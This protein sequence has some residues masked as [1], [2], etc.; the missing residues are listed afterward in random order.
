[1]FPKNYSNNVDKHVLNTFTN[2]MIK[3][4]Y[5]FKVKEEKNNLVLKLENF[6]LFAIR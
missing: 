2:I 6:E 1:M 5:G 3:L 4:V